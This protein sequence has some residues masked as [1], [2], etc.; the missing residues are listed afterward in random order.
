MKNVVTFTSNARLHALLC[1]ATVL[2]TA[3]IT[4]Q[5]SAAVTLS[6]TD[7][8]LAAPADATAQLIA[9]YATA[10]AAS[11]SI[12][13]L[14][15]SPTGSDSNPGS[16]ARPFKTIQRAANMAKPSTTVHVA[17]GT[18]RENVTTKVHGTSS[19]RIRYVSDTKWGAKIIGSGTQGMWTN[20]ANYTDIVGFDIS[21]PGRLGVLNQGSYTL[22]QGNH[23][24]NLT[25][26]G[27]CTGAGGAGIMNAVYTAS[28][29]DIIGNVVHDIGVPGK[30][31]AVHGIYHANLRGHIYNNIVYRSSSWGIH[32]WHAADKVI[33]AN[34]TSFAN[35]AGGMGG[36]IVEGVGDAP[37][38]KI[39]TNTKVINNIV[40]NNP[41]NGI[42]QYC[43]S[44]QKCIGSGNVVAN[45]LVYGNG[46]AITM[47]VGSATGTIS[48]NPQFVSYAA[49]GTAGNYRLKST[50]P[51][52]NRGI[53]T[54]APTTDIDGIARPRGG[55]FD[56][57]AYESF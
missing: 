40:Y 23:V 4:Q 43:A 10:A 13:N 46:S 52:I 34:N 5:A 28:D 41:A 8:A 12:Y 57:G 53:A 54:S 33:V 50:S 17:S 55:A 3:G 24:H 32:L 35:G 16:A 18:Y 51:A 7:Q 15:V 1:G 20:N 25:I 22:V 31:N 29:G 14:Y 42:L 9:A 27:G 36:G 19:A 48:A 49:S 11:P 21:G 56:I 47:K 26:S 45:N 2:L 44:G 39:L 6:N 38:G 37:G 30:C